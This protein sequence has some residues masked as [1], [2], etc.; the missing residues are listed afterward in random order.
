MCAAHQHFLC[1]DTITHGLWSTRAF[2][3][4]A[5]AQRNVRHGTHFAVQAGSKS[6]KGLHERQKSQKRP[7]HAAKET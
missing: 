6:M 2:L 1:K 5:M 4:R 3:T 7:S